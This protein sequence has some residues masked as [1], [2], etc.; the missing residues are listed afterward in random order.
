MLLWSTCTYL[1]KLQTISMACI[2]IPLFFWLNENNCTAF[3]FVFQ[4]LSACTAFQ[5][6]GK[7]FTHQLICIHIW[8][9]DTTRLVIVICS[10]VVPPSPSPP[11]PPFQH[12]SLEVLLVARERCPEILQQLFLSPVYHHTSQPSKDYLFITDIRA[13]HCS[14][15]L[16]FPKEMENNLN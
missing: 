6:K 9:L 1:K 15:T 2:S 11:P 13:Q 16:I 4:N 7:L 12:P 8:I 5:P 3:L 14:Q 10:R